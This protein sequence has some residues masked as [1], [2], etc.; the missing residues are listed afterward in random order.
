MALR[1]IVFVTFPGMQGLDLVGPLE[2]F[3]GAEQAIAGSRTRRAASY[4]IHVCSSTGGS[5]R[6]ESGLG[7][8][9]AALPSL[10]LAIDT[11]VVVG[12]W[13]VFEAT[14]DERLVAWLRVA[15]ARSRRLATVCTGTFLAAEA[16]LLDGLAVTTHWARADRLATD[17]PDLHVDPDPI[18]VRSGRVWTSAG[19]TAG[20]RWWK[21]T[22]APRPRRPWPAGW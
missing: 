9:T 14:R 10:D 6:T 11:I 16:G 2:V 8:D 4:E 5:V 20:S 15:G 13:G 1:R 12:G 7:I 18:W 22:T 17:H 19:V 21:P 3:A